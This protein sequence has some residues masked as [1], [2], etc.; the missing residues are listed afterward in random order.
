MAQVITQENLVQ[1]AG[2][3]L[4]A[5]KRVIAPVRIDGQVCYQ[6]LF[7]TGEMLPESEYVLP[8]ASFKEFFFPRTECVLRY[9]YDEKNQARL[10]EPALDSLPEQ[11]ILG[12]RPC[13]AASLPILDQVFGWDYKDPFYFKRREKTTVVTIACSRHD[14][15]CYC[16]S[17]GYAPDHK[18]GSDVLLKRIA[19]GSGNAGILPAPDGR[20]DAGHPNGGQ[21]ARGPGKNL[22]SG[23][24]TDTNL[25]SKLAVCPG[26]SNGGQDA[27][28]PGKYLAEALT[29]KGQALLAAHKNLFEEAPAAPAVQV[30]KLEAAFDVEKVKPWLDGHFEDAMWL[31]IASKCLGCGACA[32]GCPTC[33]C[34][35]IVDEG[36]LKSGRRLKNWDTCSSCLFTVHGSGHNPRASQEQRYRQR[37]LHKFKYYLEKFKLRACTGCGRCSV[38]CPVGLDLHEVLRTIAGRSDGPSGTVRN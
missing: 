13:D 20:R 36:D 4:A 17:I 10:E 26:L 14:E 11:V 23:E 15:Q 37:V 25:R 38:R 18:A 8:R 27:R 5:G 6:A 22:A 34:F 33:H 31:E 35:D 21:D 12:C 1:L 3:L 30:T 19:D 16:T 28:G 29:E 24:G 32:F 7:F 2:K 9:Q